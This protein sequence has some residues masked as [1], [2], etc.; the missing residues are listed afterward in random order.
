MH[1]LYIWQLHAVLDGKSATGSGGGAHDKKDKKPNW[2]GNSINVLFMYMWNLSN[3]DDT[4]RLP[5]VGNHANAFA[6]P[7]P[8]DRRTS[9]TGPQ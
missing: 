7:K 4:V 8:S 2:Q 6:K 5:P 3:A 1:S 9:R